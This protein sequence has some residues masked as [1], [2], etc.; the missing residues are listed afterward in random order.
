MSDITAGKLYKAQQ[1]LIQAVEARKAGL[2][3]QDDDDDEVKPKDV[4]KEI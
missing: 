3:N 1:Y 4:R 2:H